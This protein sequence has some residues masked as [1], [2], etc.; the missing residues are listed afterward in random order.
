MKTKTVNFLRET[1]AAS[2]FIS[3]LRGYKQDVE[4]EETNK[5]I[6]NV[7]TKDN[8]NISFEKVELYKLI[9]LKYSLLLLISISLFSHFDFSFTSDSLRHTEPP[10]LITSLA[11]LIGAT[12]GMLIMSKI[13][14]ILKTF[15]TFALV[16]ATAGLAV[17]ADYSIEFLM[18]IKIVPAFIAS[19]Y[20]VE[21]ILSEKYKNYYRSSQLNSLI[22]FANKK[23][24]F[25]MISAASLLI[26]I[27][28]L[29]IF[30]K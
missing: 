26:N 24:N 10:L 27:I 2:L 28:I 23:A 8:K 21:E 17:V 22:W 14:L 11:I 9:L 7:S 15:L 6:L 3:T 5:N 13:N 12:T 30:Q 16:I 18:A 4:I 19:F 20:L 29:L 1:T 25:W